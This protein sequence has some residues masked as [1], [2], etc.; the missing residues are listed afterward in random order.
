MKIRREYIG[1]RVPSRIFP[2]PVIG[3]IFPKA[4]AWLEVVR[5]SREQNFSRIT[6]AS[7]EFVRKV[8]YGSAFDGYEAGFH[9]LLR[10]LVQVFPADCYLLQGDGILVP[11]KPPAG[12]ITRAVPIDDER[13]VGRAD[14]TVDV[15]KRQ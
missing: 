8:E 10:R 11:S 7:Q 3:Q 5:R 9:L 4:G 14:G 15:Y 1:I 2:L 13:T 12:E 6:K